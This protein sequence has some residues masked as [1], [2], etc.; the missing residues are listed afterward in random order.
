MKSELEKIISKIERLTL[1]V[2]VN[3]IEMQEIIS[4]LKKSLLDNPDHHASVFAQ[5]SDI[6]ITVM[7]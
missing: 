6:R 5:S 4:A 1:D 7:H 2:E 3:T